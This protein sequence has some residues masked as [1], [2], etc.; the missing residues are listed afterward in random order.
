MHQNQRK[1]AFPEI[2][3]VTNFQEDNPKKPRQHNTAGGVTHPPPLSARC[4]H[5]QDL[6]KIGDFN[7]QYFQDYIECLG[8]QFATFTGLQEI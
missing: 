2:G 4:P 5:F 3:H 8:L 7:F 1:V 6:G